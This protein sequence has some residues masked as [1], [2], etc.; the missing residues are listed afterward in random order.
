[1]PH[2]QSAF[3]PTRERAIVGIS[4]SSGKRSPGTT[5]DYRMMTNMTSAVDV[6]MTIERRRFAN[7]REEIRQR[8]D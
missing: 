3:A 5:S 6:G 7:V 2:I 8:D 1:V 4:G